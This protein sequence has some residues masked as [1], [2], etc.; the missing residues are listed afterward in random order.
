[1][2]SSRAASAL[3]AVTLLAMLLSACG[4]APGG[5][6]GGGSSCTG[7]HSRVEVVV[8]LGDHHVLAR[9]VGFKGAELAGETVLH[10]SGIEFATQHFSF[11]DAVCQIDNE[12]KSYTEC[13]GTGQPYWA[14]FLWSGK[15]PWKPAATGISEVKL[16][17]GDALGWRYVP[18]QGSAPPPPRPPKT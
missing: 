10:R 8:E 4:G 3:L 12:P 16:R 14:L 5:G 13:F 7:A 2:S 1:M 15:G 9:C 11:G 18:A 17:S 6:S